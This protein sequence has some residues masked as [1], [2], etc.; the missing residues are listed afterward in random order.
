MLFR[1]HIRGSRS[2]V[3]LCKKC[4]FRFKTQYHHEVVPMNKACL[5]KECISLIWERRKCNEGTTSTQSRPHQSKS[6]PCKA[7]KRSP[8]HCRFRQG[9]EYRTR[10]SRSWRAKWY[11]PGRASTWLRPP[12]SRSRPGNARS[13]CQP[14]SRK[15]R[16][17]RE[18]RTP[19]PQGQLVGQNPLSRSPR[20]TCWRCM[21]QARR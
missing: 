6:G 7:N 15:T 5:Y 10:R 14:P 17:G 12:M 1:F 2:Q 3:T 20:G 13:S 16:R 21:R 9:K 11:R 19:R 8:P 4:S 18:H